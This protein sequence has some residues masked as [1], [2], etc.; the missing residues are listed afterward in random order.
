MPVPSAIIFVIDRLGAGYLGPYGNTWL[1]TRA[2]NR[3]ASRSV[4]CEHVLAASPEL[5][6]TYRDYWGGAGGEQT[7]LLKLAQ[8]AGYRSV[9]VTDEPELK[10]FAGAE[11]FDEL[12]LVRS[13]GVPNAPA[14]ESEGTAVAALLEVAVG[15]LA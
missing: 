5:A 11:D 10:E 6:I 13:S 4:L 7:S 3:L 2:F 12:H 14:D 9:L 1:E 8:R 15:H